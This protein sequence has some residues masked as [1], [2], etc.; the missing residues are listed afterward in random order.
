MN[1]RGIH[2]I[3]AI[4]SYPQ[5]T[6]DFYT[7]VLGLRLVKKSVNQDDVG[8]YHLFFGDRTGEPGMDLTFF[9]FQP[10]MQGERDVGQVTMISLA[11]PLSSLTFWR[12]RFQQFSVAM[13]SQQNRFGYERF[14][15]FDPDNQQLE[16]VGVPDAELRSLGADKDV[17]TTE[18]VGFEQ[19]IRCFFSAGLSVASES[20]ISPVLS[21]LGYESVG[22][23]DNSVSLWRLPE[24]EFGSHRAVFLEVETTSLNESGYPGAGT[25]HHIAFSVPDKEALRDFQARLVQIGLQPTPIIDRFYFQSVYF[26][27]RAGILLELATM[28]PGFAVDES[29]S[30]LGEKLALPPFLESQRAAIEA[31]LPEIV[32]FDSN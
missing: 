32:I 11:V 22:S 5:R 31:R 18:E 13:E 8:T 21:L 14:V 3:T 16:L 26:R 24:E 7:G 2:H 29:E 20:W 6:Y 15:F 1:V 17:W 19:A 12:E 9:T 25:V 23:R 30:T 10:A 28:G 4:A 27:T